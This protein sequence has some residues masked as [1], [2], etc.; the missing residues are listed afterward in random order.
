MAIAELQIHS[1]QVPRFG[2]VAGLR[3]REDVLFTDPKGRENRGVRK[4]AEKALQHLQE[5]L[6]RLLASDEVVLYVARAQAPVSAFEQLTLGWALYRLTTA[7][8]VLTNRRLFHFAV[9][10]NGKWRRQVRVVSWGGPAEIKASGGLLTRTLR[11]RYRNGKKEQYWN[12]RWADA[13]KIKLLLAAVLPGSAAEPASNGQMTSLCPE[14]FAA[15]TPRVYQCGQCGLV[16]KD[17]QTLIRRSILIP[18]GGY[19]YIGYL[20]LA[21]LDCFVEAMI[22]LEVLALAWL[23]VA[24]PEPARP[25]TDPNAALVA[26]LFFVGVLIL[27]KAGTIHHCRRFVRE[28]IPTKDKTA[29]VMNPPLGKGAGIRG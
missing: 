9:E 1:D 25:A 15:L 7:T 28:F 27:E 29:T 18:G 21:V 22:L 20:P 17:E 5:P 6:Q 10:S 16:F 26:L 14:C 2:T 24:K 3:V 8:L 4:R 19:F 23:L 13:R 12:L 11:L